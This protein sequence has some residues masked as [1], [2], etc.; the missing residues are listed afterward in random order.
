MLTDTEDNED[1]PF[2][3]GKTAKIIDTPSS[4]PVDE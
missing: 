1:D 4:K 3:I 2:G